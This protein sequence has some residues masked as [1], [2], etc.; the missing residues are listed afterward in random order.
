VSLGKAVDSLDMLLAKRTAALLKLENAWTE[1][2]GNPLTVESYDPSLNVRG[3]A[4]SL[5][6]ANE[7][8]GES[9]GLPRLVVPHRPR[10]ALRPMWFG[11]KVDALEWLASKFRE[12][13]EAV[14][15]KRR[16]GK[17]EAT[18]VAFVTFEE[19]AS[20]VSSTGRICHKMRGR[21]FWHSIPF[22][23]SRVLNRLADM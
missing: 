3:D 22:M 6:V 4:V 21:K 14:R 2:V 20:A 10:P 19:M 8:G 18:D 9:G 12:A 1:Y 17:F 5:R 13:D 7:D 11:R 23:R 16:L 15:R